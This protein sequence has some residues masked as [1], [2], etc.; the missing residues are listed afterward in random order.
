MA[1]ALGIVWIY[2]VVGFVLAWFA[3]RIPDVNG[4]HEREDVATFFMVAFGW[5]FILM[6]FLG[7]WVYAQYINKRY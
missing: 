7:L 2:L 4:E 1:L 6:A 3:V 5:F